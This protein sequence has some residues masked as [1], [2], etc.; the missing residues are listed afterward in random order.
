MLIKVKWEDISLSSMEVVPLHGK[1]SGSCKHR[2]NTHIKTGYPEPC[3]ISGSNSCKA[4][5]CLL[6]SLAVIND[7]MQEGKGFSSTDATASCLF[8]M[9]EILN[10]GPQDPKL[11]WMPAEPIRYGFFLTWKMDTINYLVTQNTSFQTVGQDLQQGPCKVIW[12]TRWFMEYVKN[13]QYKWTSIF[14]WNT[15]YI[16]NVCEQ[17]WN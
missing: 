15:E 17:P 3:K 16:F 14:L 2:Y 5:L 1:M 9:S 7:A 12:G 13:V 4:C 8:I 10:H 11:C 6:N